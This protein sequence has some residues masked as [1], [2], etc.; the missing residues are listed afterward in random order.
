[1]ALAPY[2]HKA[3]LGSTA[4][5]PGVSVQEFS[6]LMNPLTVTLRFGADA[7]QS[8]EGR[9]SLELVTNLLSRFYPAMCFEGIGEEAEQFGRRLTE[10]AKSINPVIELSA[11]R[12][13]Y[14]IIGKSVAELSDFKAFI[15]SDGWNACFST[16]TAQAVGLS[17]NPLG[18]GAA[19]CFGA[20]AIFRHFFHKQLGVPEP[21]EEFVLSLIDYS[22]LACAVSEPLDYDLGELALAGVGAIGNATV[23]LLARSQCKGCIHLVD[24][25]TADDTNPQRYILTN[26]ESKGR[27][28]VDLAACELGSSRLQ[29]VVHQ[30][31]WGGFVGQQPGWKIPL[32][33]V[34]LD[35]LEDRIAVQASLPKW[36]L[37]GWTQANDLGVSRHQFGSDSACLACM[38]WPKKQ[39]RSLDEVIKEAIRYSGELMDVRNML[40]FGTLL[41]ENWLER[42]AKDMSQPR[43]LL[44]PFKGK[45]IDAFYREAIC[46]GH[47]IATEGG[48]IEVPMAFQSALAGIMLAG[49]IVKYGRAGRK[50][51][52]DMITTKIDLLRPLGTHLSEQYK[53]RTDVPCICSD[54]TYLERYSEKY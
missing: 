14:L 36:I 53:R 47:I 7:I 52:T 24:P 44:E 5:M 39:T 13:P 3:A 15:G 38:Y 48:K 16:K 20:A 25:E 21:N 49:E 11:P 6:R 35:S 27:Y 33:T 54:P 32:A 30:T 50:L 4:L 18:A 42:I 10:L 51:D 19:A 37:N 1:V 46:G 34:A 2:F 45:T 43:E 40:Y 17:Q 23:W 28:K 26:P 8:H 12:S 41:D 22:R 31:T 29:P 9:V